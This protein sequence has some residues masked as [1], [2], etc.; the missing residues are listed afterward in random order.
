[1]GYLLYKP[2]VMSVV[3]KSPMTRFARKLQPEISCEYEKVTNSCF[4]VK[5]DFEK[6]EDYKR[7]LEKYWEIERINLLTKK[8]DLE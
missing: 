6:Q 7:F 3:E 2:R 1:M 8:K 5:V 4:V